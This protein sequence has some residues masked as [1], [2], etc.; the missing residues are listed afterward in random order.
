MLG[1][2]GKK[3]FVEKYEKRFGEEPT[4]HSS[5]G[6][7]AMQIMEAAVKA[8]GSFDPE[9]VREA[10]ATISANT[11]RGVYKANEQGMSPIEGVAFQIQNRKHVLV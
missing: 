6:Y 11:I 1:H 2:P 4:F 3:E 7:A 5:E 9:K 10:L 8:A